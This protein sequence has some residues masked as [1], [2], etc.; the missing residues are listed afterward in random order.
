MAVCVGS[1]Y[2]ARSCSYDGVH[3]QIGIVAVDEQTY[4]GSL[5][6]VFEG[7]PIESMADVVARIVGI[8][9]AVGIGAQYEVFGIAG[10]VQR[11]TVGGYQ[12]P[13]IPIFLSVGAVGEDDAERIFIVAFDDVVVGEYTP[14]AGTAIF[15]TYQIAARREAFAI[16][17]YLFGIQLDVVL[18]ACDE[19]AYRF[20]Q[21]ACV[22]EVVCIGLS[23]GTC[24][25]GCH[26][27]GILVACQGDIDVS[28]V[29]FGGEVVPVEGAVNLC[30]VVVGVS[31]AVGIA[32]E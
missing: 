22:A 16:G 21:L 20:F 31:P 24:Y 30:A 13:V 4:I 14:P 12:Y 11:Y 18:F 28:T 2:A 23:A 8:A 26:V 29:H 10:T 3:R 5:H 15:G 9:P 19:C 32:S 7:I 1:Q 27:D 6:I 25:N 17:I